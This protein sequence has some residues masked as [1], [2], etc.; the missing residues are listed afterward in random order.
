MIDVAVLGASGYI[1]GELVRL[2]LGHPEV[3]LAAATS[4]RFAGRRLDTVHPNLRGQTDLTFQPPDRLAD[5]EVIF[6][7]ASRTAAMAVVPRLRERT[8]CLIDLSPDFRLRDSDV[9]AR[10]YGTPHTAPDLLDDFVPGLPETHRTALASAGTISVPG[11]MA[12]AAILALRPLAPLV[13]AGTPVTVDGRI[14]SSGSGT[15]AEK[16]NLH[17]ER[18]GALRLFAPSGH[19]H[20]AEVAQAT[21]LEVRM[22]ATGVEAVR[23]AQVVC[24]VP[25]AEPRRAAEVRRRYL[26]RYR[27]EPFVR[28]VAQHRGLYRLPEPKILTG[29]NFCDVGFAVDDHTSTVIAVAALDNLV[30]GGAGNAVQCLNIRMGLPESTGLRFAGLH[31][32]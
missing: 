18:S 14:G 12:T 6:L 27:D 17:A 13:A 4:T 21:G 10:Y 28:V 16:F 7:A 19:R 23:G 9:F 3:H 26:D 1:G 2:L 20:E 15:G 24:R 22:S 32:I 31:P 30:K 29:S 11:C 8:T 5:H 25:L